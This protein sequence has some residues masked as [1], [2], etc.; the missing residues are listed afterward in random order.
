M[1]EK[2]PTKVAPAPLAYPNGGGLKMTA[3]KPRESQRLEVE[4]L[5]AKHKAEIAKLK[6]KHASVNSPAKVKKNG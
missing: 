6:E 4:A 3:N 5:E 2:S 1:F